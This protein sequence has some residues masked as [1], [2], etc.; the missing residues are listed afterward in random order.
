M[1]DRRTF[2][3]LAASAAGTLALPLGIAEAATPS[4]AERA[5]R[6]GRDQNFDIGWHFRRGEASDFE[7]PALPD[8]DWRILNLPHDWSVEDVPGG[9][10]PRQLGPFDKR[11]KGGTDTGYTQGGEGW[12]RKRFVVRDLPT[13]GIARITFEGVNVASDVW[14]NGRHLGTNL[15]GY[16][17]ASYDLTPYLVVGGANVIAVRVR[18]I[19]QNSRWYAGSGIYRSVRLDVLPH[20]ARIAPAGITASTRSLDGNVAQVDVRTEIEG[21]DPSLTVITRLRLADGKIAGEAKSP[22]IAAVSQQITIRSPALWSPSSPNLYALES[23]LRRGATV[24]DRWIQ[25]FGIRIV[26]IDAEHGMAINGTPVKLRGACIHH[27]NGLLGAC[28]FVDADERR[29]LKLKERGFNAIRSSHNPSSRSFRDAC[30]RHGMLLIEEAFDMWNVAKRKDDFSNQFAEHWR[31]PLTS[32][33]LAA[34]NNPSVIM[35][36]IGN[37]IPDRATPIG[38]EWSWKL[39]NAVHALDPTRPVT[40]GLNGVM[41]REVTASTQ[42]AR[43]GWAGRTDQASTVFLDVAGYNYGLPIIEH[44]H[45]AYPQRVIY[46]SE[47]FPRDAYDYLMLAKRSPYMLGEF[48]WAGMDYLGE[49]GIGL[50]GQIAKGAPPFVIPQF[51]LFNANC[52]DIDLIGNQKPQ[53]RA[54]DVIWG[55]SPIEIAVQTPLAD[56][57][58]EYVSLWGWSDET[59]NWTWPNAVGRSLAVRVY[60]A[61]DRV[62]LT[63]NGKNVGSK[64]MTSADKMRAELMVPYAPGVLEAIAY[65][66]SRVIGRQ[67]LKTVSAPSSLRLT[68]E[69]SPLRADKHALLHI[70]VD[71][72]DAENRIVPDAARPVSVAISGPAVLVG[73]GSANPRAVGSLQAPAAQTFNGKALLILRLSGTPGVVRVGASSDGLRGDAVTVRIKT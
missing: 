52:G 57:K 66:G 20:A 63:L 45:A 38:V 41:G 71:V 43:A 22:A 44:D 58:S 11:S 32:M 9:E 73:F 23:E 7:R 33:V 18:N 62:E 12:Y 56:G 8:D 29:I 6:P 25:P 51:P 14:L 53:S 13:G 72:T 27:D 26:T 1:Q 5:F 60:T 54:R 16:A 30:D 15:Y 42:T 19:G 28:A 69:R 64:S 17:P 61:G 24:L 40:A 68:T 39:A 31:E 65:V 35:W 2:L 50:N 10:A 3:A 59:P 49:A 46:A 4:A 70:G 37:E 67:R 21:A 55:L 36:S 34:R 47:T 48:V